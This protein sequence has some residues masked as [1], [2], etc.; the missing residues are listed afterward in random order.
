MYSLEWMK[1]KIL[2]KN[3]IGILSPN[4]KLERVQE[5]INRKWI[6][7][8]VFSGVLLKNKRNKQL[9]HT[10]IWMNLKNIMLNKL[11]LPKRIH[12]EWFHLHDILEYV[13]LITIEKYNRTE[14]ASGNLNWLRRGMRKLSR[15]LCI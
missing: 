5:Y 4:P 7:K 11:V 3:N 8:L 6:N 1:V 9:T 10:T 12:T 13:K 15:V 14:L 2:Y